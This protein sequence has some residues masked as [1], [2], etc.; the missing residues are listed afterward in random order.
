ME[1]TFPWNGRILVCANLAYDVTPTDLRDHFIRKGKL[2]RVD[3][4]RNKAGDPN[5]LAF[6]EFNSASDCSSATEFDQSQFHGRTLK[7]K[8]ASNPPAELIRYYIRPLDKR[9]INDRVRERILSGE[10]ERSGPSSLMTRKFRGRRDNRRPMERKQ[11]YSDYTYY[12][13]DYSDY[14]SD[15]ESRKTRK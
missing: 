10:P 1:E 15:E 6:I 4:E 8:V 13:S 5:G 2:L 7:C 3:V 12:Y 14:D 11:D 9:P